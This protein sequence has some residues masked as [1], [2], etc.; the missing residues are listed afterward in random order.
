MELVSHELELDGRRARLVLA[1][2]TTERMRALAALHQS[3]E[4]CAT[5]SGPRP[6][7]GSRAGSPTT[8]TTC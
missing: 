3:E 6:S 4:H 8:S 1:T 5:P 2:D 7:A